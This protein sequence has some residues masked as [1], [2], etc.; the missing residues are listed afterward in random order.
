MIDVTCV[1]SALIDSFLSIHDANTNCRFNEETRELCFKHGQKIPLDSATFVLG[2]NACNVSVGIARLG[3]KSSLVAEIGNDAFAHKILLSLK[4][5]NVDT[6]AIVRSH[7]PSSFAFG[8]NFNGERTLFVEHIKRKHE[9]RFDD[10][11]S[12]YIY[13]TSMGDEWHEAYS[14]TL[15]FVK[16][17]K[18]KLAFNPGSRQIADGAEEFREI[19]LVTD[20]FFIN[21]EEAEKLTN[22]SSENTDTGDYVE[23]MK[24]LLHLIQKM[25]PKIV[26][27]TDGEKGSFTRDEDGACRMLPIYPCEVVEK[28]GAGDSYATAFLGGMLNGRSI[29]E[30]MQWGAINAAAVIEQIGAQKGLLTHNAI[31]KKL[32][33]R[34]SERPQVI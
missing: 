9:F 10:V 7:A 16:E 13:L 12:R 17:T 33:D 23:R 11:K 22:I 27:L 28:T 21:K 26:V 15:Q 4:E 24:E 3:L 2:G 18:T 6:G 29:A 19:L 20:I 34:T 30:S 1:G 5:E 25:G 14:R 32:Y 8:I 31:E